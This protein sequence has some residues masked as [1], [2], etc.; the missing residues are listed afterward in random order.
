MVITLVYP[1]IG[2]ICVSL[3]SYTYSMLIYSTLGFLSVALFVGLSLMDKLES[4]SD[5]QN[6]WN[7]FLRMLPDLWRLFRQDPI[8]LA[9]FSSAIGY[10]VMSGIV[11][12]YLLKLADLFGNTEQYW[13]FF[14]SAQGME[15]FI[16]SFFVAYPSVNLH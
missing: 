6:L 11:K 2:G 10:S 13:G 8:V 7:N 16:G 4:E 14:L 12:I 1:P 9:F 3:F 15:A 5:H